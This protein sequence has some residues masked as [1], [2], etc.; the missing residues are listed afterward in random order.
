MR[1]AFLFAVSLLLAATL[2][3]AA[4]AEDAVVAGD[5]W[6]VATPK[7]PPP[8]PAPT[9]TRTPSSSWSHFP[10]MILPRP[11]CRDYGLLELSLAGGESHSYVGW[12]WAFRGSAEVGLLVAATPHLHGGP[13]LEVGFD[14][15]R[16]TSGWSAVPK[17]RGR[18]WLG[19]SNFTLEGSIG[20]LFERYAFNDGYEA[21]N[22]V[23]AAA[24]LA[25][26]YHGAGSLLGSVS[27]AA[28]PTG[29]GGAEVRLL[30]GLR[31]S[32]LTWGLIAAAPFAGRSNS[33]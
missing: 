28:D 1:A 25:F 9:P 15:G 20:T 5:P 3:P 21:R 31:A 16:V 33:F 4:S 24:D 32:L 12:Q 27:F 8:A 30:V 29:H 23:G 6:Q 7:R 14:L 17:V 18:L 10:C 13:A 2:A 26:S 19:E 22:R 11:S